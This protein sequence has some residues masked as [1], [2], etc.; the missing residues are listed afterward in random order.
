M[1]NAD[2]I[3]SRGAY[4]ALFVDQP[5]DIN[6]SALII[7]DMQRYWTDPDGPMSQLLRDR[8][9]DM[10]KYFYH[11]LADTVI[12]QLR[13]VLE[14]YREHRLPVIHVTTGAARHDTRDLLPHLHRRAEN[15]NR[16]AA[17]F[18]TLRIG[19]AW[20]Q[21]T[22]ELVPKEGEILLNKTSRSAFS[23]T[24]IDSILR[25]LLV[26]H[27]VVGGIATDGCVF[28]TALDATDHGYETFLLADGTGTFTQD[29]HLSALSA[30]QRLWGRVLTAGEFS[31]AFESAL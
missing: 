30:F 13:A 12:P 29:I 17:E 16:E 1:N 22:A 18:G 23:S 19:S 21:V 28:L 27:A 15:P 26:Q 3:P 2:S 7:V 4:P 9:P 6:R 5:I 11:R 20:Q 25:N 31:G 14:R 10:N 24:G 8:F